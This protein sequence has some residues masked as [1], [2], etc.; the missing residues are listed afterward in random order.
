M[1]S[2]PPTSPETNDLT[3]GTL[4]G[5]PFRIVRA[6]LLAILVPVLRL[7]IE[8]LEHVPQTGAVLLV[9]NHLHNADPVLVSVAFPRPLHFMAKKELFPIPVIGPIIRRVGALSR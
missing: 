1:K 8:G 9:G 5:I 2:P 7:K 6:I 3:R 4:R